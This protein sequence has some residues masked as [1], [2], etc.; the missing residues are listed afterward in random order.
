MYGYLYINNFDPSITW[1]NFLQENDDD[2]GSK[3]FLIQYAL[4]ANVTYILIATTFSTRVFTTFSIIA[5]GPAHVSFNLI[6]E[7]MIT[8]VPRE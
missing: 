2:G 3:Q 8:T 7:T 6:D 4:Q 5:Q 1:N